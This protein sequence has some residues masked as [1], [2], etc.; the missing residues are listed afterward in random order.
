VTRDTGLRRPSSCRGSTEEIQA[1]V[2]LCNKAGIVFKPSARAFEY[3]ATY[4]GQERGILLEL[5]RLEPHPGDRRQ[6]HARGG[7][8]VRDHVSAAGRR[9]QHGFYVGKPGVGY[10]AAVISLAC[11]TRR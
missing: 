10:S 3:V 7:R 5:K 6:E 11:A 9:R 4:L 1:I 8:A 2:R